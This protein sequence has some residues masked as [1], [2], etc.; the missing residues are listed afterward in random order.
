MLVIADSSPMNH[1]IR[2]GAIEA[3]P[4]LFGRVVIPTEVLSELTQ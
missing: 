3:L 2:I 1:L 4:K